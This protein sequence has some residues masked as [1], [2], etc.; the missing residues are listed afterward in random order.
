MARV[1][2][3]PNISKDTSA[4]D[5]RDI[6]VDAGV[7]D[8]DAEVPDDYN[9]DA[10]P[11]D[12]DELMLDSDEEK[13]LPPPPSQ[14]PST[15]NSSPPPSSLPNGHSSPPP[16]RPPYPPRDSHASHPAQ[17][18]RK[19]RPDGV[20]ADPMGVHRMEEGEIPYRSYKEKKK[21]K[22]VVTLH[23]DVCDLTLGEIPMQSHLKGKKHK[24]RE[25]QAA[26]TERNKKLKAR[27]LANFSQNEE[28]R[29]PQPANDRNSTN[30]PPQ[31]LTAGPS[32]MQRPS[33]RVDDDSNHI[34]PSAQRGTTRSTEPPREARQAAP[35]DVRSTSRDPTNVP[36]QRLSA[37]P[38][39]M[40]RPSHGADDVS[41]HRDTNVERGTTRPTEPPREARQAAPD[42]S[43]GT[44]RDPTNVPP[45][46][47]SAGPSNMQRPSQ[48]VDD[49][50]NNRD[51]NVQRGMT[52]PTEPPR[53]ARQAAADDSRTTSRDPR[54]K[55][56]AT[57][58]DRRQVGEKEKDASDP[59]K[60]TDPYAA[61]D[62]YATRTPYKPFAAGP[63][64]PK[65]PPSPKAKAANASPP[66]NDPAPQQNGS[67]ETRRDS[68]EGR[69]RKHP[70]DGLKRTPNHAQRTSPDRVP[71]HAREYESTGDD[72]GR[73]KLVSSLRDPRQQSPYVNSL[74]T[75]PREQKGLGASASLNE[76]PEP[77]LQASEPM[78]P[79]PPQLTSVPAP[80][81]AGSHAEQRDIRRPPDQ[82]RRFVYDP[83]GREQS[84]AI[85][86][87]WLSQTM[88]T[89]EWRDLR[90]GVFERGTAVDRLAY[91]MLQEILLSPV[92]GISGKSLAPFSRAMLGAVKN[93][94]ITSDE[95]YAKFSDFPQ[96]LT[97]RDENYAKADPTWQK[98]QT[99]EDLALRLVSDN[100]LFCLNSYEDNEDV[101]STELHNIPRRGSFGQKNMVK[102]S[103]D[104]GMS[105]RYQDSVEQDELFNELYE[106]LLYRNTSR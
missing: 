67:R 30:V 25:R 41:N 2:A 36:P 58:A 17:P 39:N 95:A 55:T 49:D 105:P 74:T 12:D 21:K 24:T 98:S 19:P 1:P 14:P 87:E 52:R 81:L 8:V 15:H 77:S 27:E 92:L 76:Q 96:P 80:S 100:I 6:D 22:N 42:D 102:S 43:R 18:D 20:V 69:K 93:Q 61:S 64:K 53:D 45:Q 54:L 79:R 35:D 99:Q 46:R 10:L 34:D 40:Q 71:D 94:R 66:R 90:S 83:V 106:H 48:R 38:S 91:K 7:L 68:D 3:V 4:P 44:S 60:P 47:L 56:L 5:E 50:S 89:S 84:V 59:R 78:T 65:D 33:Q 103:R 26:I 28:P 75:Q 62:P 31:R 82:T 63:M 29:N 57:D 86:V 73:R 32:S 9:W 51:T 13:H 72:T 104:G 97:I 16:S 11:D 37:G 70:D 101:G 88:D 23:C 85:P